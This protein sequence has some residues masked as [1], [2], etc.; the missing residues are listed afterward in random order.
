MDL[1]SIIP[2]ADIKAI[3]AAKKITFHVNGDVGGIANPDPQLR[4][5]EGMEADFVSGAKAPDNPAF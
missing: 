3:T 2:A 5:A 4:V 1:A